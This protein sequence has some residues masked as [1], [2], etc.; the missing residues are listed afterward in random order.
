MRHRPPVRGPQSVPLAVIGIGLFFSSL[1]AHQQQALMGIELVLL[2]HK[3]AR[4]PRGAAAPQQGQRGK[5]LT[6]AAMRRRRMVAIE[7]G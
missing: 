3:L 6:M 7:F 2:H 5:R 4:D 1:V